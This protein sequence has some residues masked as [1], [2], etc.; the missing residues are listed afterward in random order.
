MTFLQNLKFF[1]AFTVIAQNVS[2]SGMKQAAEIKT[3]TD[4]TVQYV[5]RESMF[6]T[7]MLQNYALPFTSTLFFRYFTQ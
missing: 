5:K 1:H 4:L 6:Q 2:F 7:E 3:Q